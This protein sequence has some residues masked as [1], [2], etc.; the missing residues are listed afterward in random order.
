M[1]KSAIIRTGD[2]ADF[3]AADAA[4]FELFSFCTIETSCAVATR[5]VDRINWLVKADLAFNHLI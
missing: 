2:L 1:V 5:I 4:W 3:L